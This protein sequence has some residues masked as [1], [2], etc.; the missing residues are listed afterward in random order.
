MCGGKR[1]DTSHL[2]TSRPKLAPPQECT[3]RKRLP[4]LLTPTRSP[5]GPGRW[6]HGDTLERPL[7]FIYNK[8]QRD[9]QQQSFLRARG[10][11]VG[12]LP[13]GHV[14]VGL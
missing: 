7:P 1:R 12:G 3:S 4:F 2:P 6:D 13:V 14:P 9:T 8:G 11:T 5:G 10:L